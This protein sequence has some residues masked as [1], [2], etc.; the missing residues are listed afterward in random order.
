MELAEPGKRGALVLEDGT[1][2]Q[3]IGFGAE[4]EISGEVVFNTSMMG[5]PELLTDPLPKGAVKLYESS[6]HQGD[7]LNCIRSRKL[8]ICDVEIGAR[9]VTVCHL[10]NIAYW[11]RKTIKWDPKAW[12]FVDPASEVAKWFD[13]DRR[14]PWQLPKV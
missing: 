7:W 10:G 8:P 2:I 12:Q 4:T 3:G 6:S 13:R 5:Y 14:D 9:S 11:T 1:V